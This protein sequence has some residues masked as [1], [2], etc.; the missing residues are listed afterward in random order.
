MFCLTSPT[1]LKILKIEKEG[2]N[3]KLFSIQAPKGFTFEPGQ[4]VMVG[5]PGFGEAPIS[6]C[7]EAGKNLP[8][9][10]LAIRLVGRLTSALHQLK[11]GDYLF[12]RG[13]FGRGFPIEKASLLPTLVVAGGCGIEPVRP[14]I[15]SV[16][17]NPHKYK[18]VQIFYGARSEEDIVFAKEHQIWAEK[19]QVQVILDKAKSQKYQQGLVTDLFKFYDVSEYKLAFLCGPPVMY[20][21]VLE[22]LKEKNFS[23]ENV[24]LSLERRM[25][26]GM[27]LCQHCVIGPYYVCKD[28]PVFSWQELQKIKSIY[29][30]I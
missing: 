23:P 17:N 22:K 4:F 26:C 14:F 6:I 1:K 13:P 9:F 5:L 7:S 20:R 3:S 18:K 16:V 28:G 15:L 11:A 2:S 29:Q 8:S 27:G 25:E 30:I 24:F 21:F 12:I 19:C 10:E